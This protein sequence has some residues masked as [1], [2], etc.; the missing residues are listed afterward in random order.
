MIKKNLAN[1]DITLR[2][3]EVKYRRKPNSVNLLAVS[4]TFPKEAVIDAYKA[5]QR[6]FGENYLQ[7][8]LSKITAVEY[9]DIV[10]HFI[11]PIQS[12]KTKDIAQNFHWVHTLDR[13][14]IARRLNNQRAESMAPLNCC[15]QVNI[16]KDEHKSG[17]LN[18][19]E[20]QELA[21]TI[22]TLPHLQ[23]KGLMAIP[24]SFSSFDEQK[25]EFDKLVLI[26]EQLKTHFP[27]IDCLSMGM[28]QDIE[29]AVAAG[30]TWV[31]IGTG[32][33]GKRT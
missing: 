27:K 26:F 2:K 20:I 28:T 9:T 19:N 22:E 32:I 21:H 15:I 12:N 11:G 7:D 14:K 13:E 17:L 3:L 1:T 33:F 4:K 18:Y 16:S 5:G 6:H 23:L 25:R 30:S 24:K 8:A 31:R 29:A 10:W